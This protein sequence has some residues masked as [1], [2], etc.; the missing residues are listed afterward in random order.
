MCSEINYLPARK[1]TVHRNEFVTAEG[2][3]SGRV[4]DSVLGFGF[5][6]VSLGDRF[7]TFRKKKGIFIETVDF[8][9]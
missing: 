2:S 3:Y 9:R 8:G 7:P 5:G 4:G 6:A 1:H